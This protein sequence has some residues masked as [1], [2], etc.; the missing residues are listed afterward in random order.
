MTDN[1]ANDGKR[2][3]FASF[4]EVAWHRL[5]TVFQ[6]EVTSSAQMLDLAGLSNW[7]VREEN[8]SVVGSPNANFAVPAK[9]IVAT[10]PDGDRVLGVTGERYKIVQNEEAFSFLQSLHDGARWETAGAIKDGRVVF[11]SMAFSRDFV[12]DESGVADKVESYLLV[13]TSHDGSTG[14]AGGV[15]PVRVVC[16][17]TL[18][19]AIP[20]V[21]Q[22]FKIRHTTNAQERMAA[23][24]VL[25]RGAYTYMD[26]FETEARELYATKATTKDYLSIVDDIFPKP[27]KDVKGALSK[28][29][30]RRG[31]FVQAWNGKPNAGIKGT[32][33]GVFNA[34]TEANQWGR[35]TRKSGNGA[36]N[37]AA[38]GAGFDIPTNQFRATALARAKALV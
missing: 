19:A 29:E 26:A 2:D 3:L 10:M 35:S 21:K 12:I 13:Y 34:L 33:W 18:N 16:Q 4:R 17:N 14:V 1:I 7:N 27:E 9:A 28:W 31:L 20:G 24:S 32:A 25:W 5:G 23:E 38:A 15:T 8:I 37:F 30:N 36:E 6:S 11:G 22:S